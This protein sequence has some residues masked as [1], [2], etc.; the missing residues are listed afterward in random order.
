MTIP[1]KQPYHLGMNEE[2]PKSLRV[3]SVGT[4]LTESEYERLEALAQREGLSL[5]EWLRRLLLEQAESGGGRPGAAEEILLGE[6][7]A[8]RTIL[9]NVL[10]KLAQG[11]KLTP[12]EM[13]SL[14]ER[15]DRDKGRKARTKLEQAEATGGER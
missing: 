15:A 13:Q 1:E 9:L 12:E 6:V 14:I 3:R 10:Y 8:L 7:L 4:K 5:S 2:P 11:E